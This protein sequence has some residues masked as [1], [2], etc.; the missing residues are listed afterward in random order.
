MK[1]EYQVPAEVMTENLRFDMQ[2]CHSNERHGVNLP[3]MTIRRSIND[4]NQPVVMVEYRAGN[5]GQ[6][7]VVPEEVFRRVHNRRRLGERD[8]AEC[9]RSSSRFLPKRSRNDAGPARQ[10]EKG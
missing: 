7:T 2:G 8:A 9:V 5:A 10:T 1:L 4:T 6:R 3:G